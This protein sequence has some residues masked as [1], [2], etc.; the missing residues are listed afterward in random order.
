MTF[1]LF[2]KGASLSFLFD[3]WLVCPSQIGRFHHVLRKAVDLILS[4]EIVLDVQI[5]YNW[6]EVLQKLNGQGERDWK[7]TVFKLPS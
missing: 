5:L 2:L 1:F 7:Q 6:N 4:G 3:H